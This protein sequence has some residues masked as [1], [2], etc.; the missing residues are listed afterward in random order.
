MF[1]PTLISGTPHVRS[2][3][4]YA[5]KSL[6]YIIYAEALLS[7]L[8]AGVD[9]TKYAGTNSKFNK[10]SPAAKCIYIKHFRQQGC[11]SSETT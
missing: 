9:N 1:V 3:C 6:H 5:T 8:K 10:K 2:R 11:L 4:R 7:V